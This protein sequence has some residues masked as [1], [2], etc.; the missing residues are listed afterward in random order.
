MS[1]VKTIDKLKQNSDAADF[2]NHSFYTLLT[3]ISCIAYSIDMSVWLDHLVIIFFLRALQF[4][5]FFTQITDVTRSRSLSTLTVMTVKVNSP[6]KLKRHDSQRPS[7]SR[8]W[9]WKLLQ[10]SFHYPCF[11]ASRKSFHF[12]V[13]FIMNASKK[14]EKPTYEWM[15]K[16]YCT[17]SRFTLSR[18]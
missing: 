14:K 17:H 1:Q 11:Q 6:L 8:R 7:M 3:P 13:A 12:H 18:K 5:E 9:D 15:K 2:D 16:I 10:C 4:D